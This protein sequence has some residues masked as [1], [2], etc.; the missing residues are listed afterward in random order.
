MLRVEQ[1]PPAYELLRT[2]PTFR[3]LPPADT[4]GFQLSDDRTVFGKLY[5]EPRPLIIISRRKHRHVVSWLMTMAHEM[6]H[7]RL[8]VDAVRTWDSHGDEI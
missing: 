3:R 2:F 7:F 6:V 8:A 5:I 4:V 1:L